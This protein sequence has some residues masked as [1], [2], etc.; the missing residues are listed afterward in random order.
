MR[1][2]TAFSVAIAAGLLGVASPVVGDDAKVPEKPITAEERAHWAF[3]PPRP[4]RPPNDL[5]DRTWC[6]NPI[7]VFIAAALKANNLAPSPEAT[8]S[9][10]LRRLSFDLTGLPPTPDEVEAFLG[11]PDPAAYEKV[12]DR[13]LANPQYGVR[14]A[15][16]WLDLARYADTDG[17][18]FDQARPNAWRYRDWVVESLNRDLP[19]DRFVGLQLAGDEL[20]P[21]DPGA[22]IATGL[23]RCYPDMVDLND[24]G[25]RRQN[26]LNDITE[27]TGLVFLGLTIGCARCHDHK[28]DPIRQVDF[29]R[30]QAFFTPSQFRDDFPIP[31]DGHRS[32]GPSPKSGHTA[33]VLEESREQA[34]PT[35]FLKRGEFNAR[36][37]IVEPAFP[38]VLASNKPAMS[39]APGSSGR[40]KA[41]AEW[42]TNPGHPLTS[43]VMVNR[44][45]QQHFGRGLVETPSDFGTMGDEPSL[46]ELLDWLALEFIRQGWSMKAIHRLIVTSATYRQASGKASRESLANDPDN[47]LLSRQNRRR[48]DGEAIRDALLAVSGRLNPAQGG[49]GIFPALPSELAKLSSKGAVWPVSP[50]PEEQDRRSLYVFVRRNLRYPFFESFD[51]PDTNASCARRA[52]TTIAPQA[53]SLLNGQLSTGAAQTLADRVRREAGPEI[54]SMV[55]RAYLL[56]FGRPPDQTE[57]TLAHSFLAA[58]GATFTAY[59]LALL[60]LNEFIYVD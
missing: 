28:F 10:L 45:W 31:S 6:R 59:C 48:L 21:G 24:Q 18:E 30:L 47:R 19:Y 56:A 25:L 40:R 7:D 43:R 29:Y 16:H 1:L 54:G 55:H 15:Q 36:G 53:L 46:P 14:S 35:Y 11:D 12:V 58:D 4:V 44:L 34:P 3:Q 2:A 9:T 50:K 5:G 39:P 32:D 20:A 17:F 22:H 26:A 57:R 41:L 13:L 27:T 37:P 52:V 51:R 38:A 8:R 60:N 42:L 23:N 49:P 33:R